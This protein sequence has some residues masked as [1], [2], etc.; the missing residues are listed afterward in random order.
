MYTV[1]QTVLCCSGGHPHDSSMGK[2]AKATENYSPHFAR[3][4]LDCFCYH[5]R[6]HYLTDSSSDCFDFM[7]P[8]AREN[9][10]QSNRA[11]SLPPVACAIPCLRRTCDE[12][13][14]SSVGYC[15]YVEDSGSQDLTVSNFAHVS[16]GRAIFTSSPRSPTWIPT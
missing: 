5:C 8:R 16:T 3:W 7:L 1:S 6:D 12:D 13:A 4:L 11:K 10:N 14:S 15:D 2:E 9:S